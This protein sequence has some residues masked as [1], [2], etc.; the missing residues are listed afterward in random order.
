MVDQGSSNSDIEDFLSEEGDNQIAR[1][2][3]M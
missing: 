1:S 3:L 2:N